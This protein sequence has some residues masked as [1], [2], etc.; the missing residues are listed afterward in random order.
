[1]NQPQQSSQEDAVKF[2]REGNLVG[3]QKMG[4]YMPEV[5]HNM[6]PNGWTVLHES[7]R[8]GHLDMVQFL[9]GEQAIDKNLITKTGVSPLSIAKE[10]KGLDH[11]VTKFLESIGA[12]EIHPHKKR[13]TTTIDPKKPPT[14]MPSSVKKRLYGDEL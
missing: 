14:S 13:R 9:I 3:L 7:V 8:A 1:M 4:R 12:E 5:Y 11:P 10:F 2:A 6:D